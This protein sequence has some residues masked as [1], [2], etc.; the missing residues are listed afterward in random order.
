MNTRINGLK[1]RTVF[2][3]SYFTTGSAIVVTSEDGTEHALIVNSCYLDEIICHGNKGIKDCFGQ[4]VI[5][6]E[7]VT[8][9]L[10]KIRTMF[11]QGKL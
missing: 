9:G 4:S 1:T 10:I 7:D 2:D 3:T 5:R 6:I 8:G 11:R